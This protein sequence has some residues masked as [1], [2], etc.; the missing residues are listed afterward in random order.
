MPYPE[1]PDLTEPLKEME[2]FARLKCE[3]GAKGVAR[4]LA[5]IE[6]QLKAAGRDMQ[7]LKVDPKQAAREPDSLRAIQA[8]RPRGPRRMAA[9]FDRKKYLPRLEGALLARMAACILGAPVEGWK[10]WRMKALARENGEKF[11]PVDYWKAVSEPWGLQYGYSPRGTY[12]RGGRKFPDGSWYHAQKKTDFPAAQWPVME[13]VDK[14]AD[15]KGV[16]SSQFSLAWCLHVPGVTCPI[17]GPRTLAQVKDNMGATDVTL[18][19]ADM[20]AV[21]A[22]NAPGKLCRD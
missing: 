21:D 10:P 1:F 12:T 4:I 6:R 20:K 3:H 17:I 11:P 13:A 18:T 14:M 5:R 22:L 2:R 16:T 15:E 7:R 19:D 8:L 9:A